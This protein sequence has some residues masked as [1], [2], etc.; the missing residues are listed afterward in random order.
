VTSTEDRHWHGMYILVARTL[1][2]ACQPE[3]ALAPGVARA[4]WVSSSFPSSWARGNG[5]GGTAV[6]SESRSHGPSRRGGLGLE[7]KLLTGRL[8]Q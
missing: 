5:H 7:L 6:P 3:C 1:K 2:R 8:W 4:L